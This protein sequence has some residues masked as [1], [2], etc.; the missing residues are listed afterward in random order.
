MEGAL[1][2]DRERV[3]PGPDTACVPRIGRIMVKWR[4]PGSMSSSWKTV[5]AALVCLFARAHGQSP[6][7]APLHLPPEI[8]AELEDWRVAHGCGW[9]LVFDET[10]GKGRM[11][12]GGS[13]EPP[14][15]PVN[16]AQG[17]RL[18]RH[19]IQQAF[20]LLGVQDATLVTDRWI[21]LPLAGLGTSDKVSIRFRQ[22]LDGVPVQDAS[23]NVLFEV[24]TARLLS[25]DSTAMP[26]VLAAGLD[27]LPSLGA[28]EA[29]ALALS[30][31]VGELGLLPDSGSRASLRIIRRELDGAPV[32]AWE[33]ALSAVIEE[34]RISRVYAVDAHAPGSIVA[35]SD[36]VYRATPP[37][38]QGGTRGQVL[39]HVTPDGDGS[40]FWPWYDPG[41]RASPPVPLAHLL[42]RTAT[43]YTTTTDANG[44]FHVPFGPGAAVTLRLGGPFVQEVDSRNEDELSVTLV[45]GRPFTQILLDPALDES[46]V[47]QVN[48]FYRVNQM[49]D[50][51]RAINPHDDRMDGRGPGLGYRVLVNNTRP[52]QRPGSSGQVSATCNAE[53]DS[54]SEKIKFSISTRP[55]G[56]NCPNASFAPV[57]WHEMGHWL[58]QRYGNALANAAVQPRSVAAFHEGVADV[59]ALYQMDYP[60]LKYG[61]VERDG[62]NDPSQ[63]YFCGDCESE[64]TCHSFSAHL[65]GLPIMGAL[66]K[67]RRELEADHGAGP[68]ARIA[69]TLFLGWM[70]AYDQNRIHSIIEYQWLVLDDD[71]HD[72]SNRTP[73]FP[74]IDRGFREQRFPGFQDPV[75]S[76][77][78]D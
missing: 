71:D 35:W 26:L 59:F 2:Q 14:F 51:V 38:A 23:V 31:F 54:F 70:N 67:V 60:L 28:D 53:F 78:C 12:F 29:R 15:V 19:W 56:G 68:G 37:A 11:L 65:N 49:R 18:A 40:S 30:S 57:L 76:V 73:H 43:G 7:P 20:E 16:A 41:A 36:P 46:S 33:C 5:P 52:C 42:V 17:V 21:V 75:T 9:H 10:T 48:A 62:E 34:N 27:T 50:W 4:E 74:A 72:L 6:C 39:A 24:S 58:I 3:S 61:N 63:W 77:I 13:A 69:D 32:L 8:R 64:Q 25:I 1:D 55:C 22:E 66:W 45:L 47:A 44:M